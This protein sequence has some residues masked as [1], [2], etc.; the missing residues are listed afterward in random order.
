MVIIAEMN[1]LAVGM[2]KRI[3]QFKG[4]P[5]RLLNL[6]HGSDAIR[7]FRTTQYDS[8][9][10]HWHLADM[11][12]GHFLR[13]LKA[14]MPKMPVIAIIEPNNPQQEIE[15]RRLGVSAVVSEDCDESYFRQI[16]ASVFGLSNVEAIETL[17]AVKDL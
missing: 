15:A 16:V 1:V 10:S 9:I 8:V 13:R 6:T 3:A 4:L 5:I 7:S 12:N 11:P 2:D 14:A 17:Y